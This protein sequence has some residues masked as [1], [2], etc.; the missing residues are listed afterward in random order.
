MASVGVVPGT[1]VSVSINVLPEEILSPRLFLGQQTDVEDES[2]VRAIEMPTR[3]AHH[4][5]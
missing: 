4:S 2:T 5:L 1:V 3:E